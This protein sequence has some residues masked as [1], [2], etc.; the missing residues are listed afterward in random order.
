MERKSY[1]RMLM[2]STAECAPMIKKRYPTSYVVAQKWHKHSTRIDTIECYDHY[3]IAYRKSM[4]L[5][6]LKTLYLGMSKV[7]QF[8][9]WRVIKL[10]YCEIFHGTWKNAQETVPKNLI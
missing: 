6:N 7:T 9:V 3:T 4:S 5:V 1:K 10:K 2:K 8:H